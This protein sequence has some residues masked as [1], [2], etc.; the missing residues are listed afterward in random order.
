V[1]I[2]ALD[3]SSSTGSIAIAKNDRISFIS[4][5]DIKATHSERLMPQ[6]DQGLEMTGLK[7]KDIDLIC[8][9]NGPGSFTGI[10]IGLATAKGLSL[11]NQIPLLPFNTLEVIAANLY[12]P[13][14]PL[15]VLLDAKMNEI[16]GALF[17]P[18]HDVL[19]PPQNA[20]PVDFLQNITGKVIVMG[21]GVQKYKALLDQAAFDYETV[22]A[23][24]ELLLA[25]SM[26]GL[27]LQQKI[28]PQFDF[29]LIA[30]LEPYYLRRSQ[31]E[32]VRAQKIDQEN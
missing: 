2:L 6:I 15:L 24:Q 32:I 13:Q 31:A 19:I 3:T 26:I 23:H 4:M 8:V 22:Q 16:Y 1:N 11:G 21:D 14:H 30:D 7:V 12:K 5:L 20:D 10:R 28:E 29:E 18:D 27:A 17:S 25:S 9:G